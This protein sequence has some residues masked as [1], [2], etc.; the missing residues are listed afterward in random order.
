MTTARERTRCLLQTGPFLERIARDGRVP[1]ALRQEAA[2]LAR[3]YP[4]R[5]E[6]H[7]VACH[8]RALPRQVLEPVL[9]PL[10]P[11]IGG[12]GG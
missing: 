3:H 4:G 10:L 9:E 11:P 2:A 8:E 12:N 6:L 7:L 5:I 1:D